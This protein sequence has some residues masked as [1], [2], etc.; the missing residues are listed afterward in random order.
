[1]W[2]L[3]S[4]TIS[5]T[6][7][8]GTRKY[9]GLVQHPLRQSFQFGSSGGWVCKTVINTILIS[10]QYFVCESLQWNITCK[11][12]LLYPP[13]LP[14]MWMSNCLKKLPSLYNM[15]DTLTW[16]IFSQISSH[17]SFSWKLKA[18]SLSASDQTTSV[19]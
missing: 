3:L 1:M 9:L 8:F 12:N 10:T 15:T 13:S 14:W 11:Q 2:Y 18:T 17:P 7:I 4:L 16:Q 5:R 19:G 6:N